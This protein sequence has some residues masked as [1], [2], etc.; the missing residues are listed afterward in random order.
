MLRKMKWGR[1][2]SS[3]NISSRVEDA[4][5]G[6]T[7]LQTFPQPMSGGGFFPV[8]RQ[9]EA[10]FFFAFLFCE[11]RGKGAYSDKKNMQINIFKLLEYCAA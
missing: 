9:S 7:T 6:S 11:E 10:E 3:R 2:E 5:E 4:F 8:I 1:A